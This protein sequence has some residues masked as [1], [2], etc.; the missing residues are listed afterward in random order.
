M[1]VPADTVPVEKAKSFQPYRAVAGFVR[2]A[3]LQPQ[4]IN[5]TPVPTTRAS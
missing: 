3:L 4:R 1:P 5:E 2:D